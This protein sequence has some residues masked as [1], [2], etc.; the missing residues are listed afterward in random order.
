[1]RYRMLAAL[2]VPCMACSCGAS[3]STIL[4]IDTNA[5]LDTSGDSAAD[6]FGP[7]V[8]AEGIGPETPGFEVPPDAASDTGDAGCQTGS[9]CFGDPCSGADDCTSG[10]CVDHMGDR[11]CTDYCVEECPAGWACLQ[12]PGPDLLFA[13]ASDFPKLCRPC[14]VDEDCKADLGG[15]GRCLSYGAEGSFCGAVCGGGKL[16]PEDFTCKDALTVDGVVVSQCVANAGTCSCSAT[17]VALA[18]ST[19]CAVANQAGSCPGVRVCTEQGLTECDAATPAA[20]ECNGLDDD[21]NGQTDE[22]T[23][24]DGNDCT[25]DGCVPLTGCFHEELGGIPCNDADNCTLGDQCV[26][27][28]CVG[29]LV[30]CEDG[31]PCTDD[32]CDGT[33]GCKFP[34]SSGLCDDD[35]PCTFGD[36]CQDGKCKPG[37]ALS[38][39]DGND[40]T[41]DS[42]DT[43]VGCLHEAADASCDDG[44]P[45]TVGDACLDG[46]CVAGG[47]MDCDDDNPC[48]DDWCGPGG[49][50]HVPNT[51]PCNDGSSCTVDDACSQGQCAGGTA[52]S[53]DDGNPCTSDSCNPLLGCKHTN[54]SDPCD[55]SDPCTLTDSC[56]G[57]VCIGVGAQNCDDDNPCTTDFCEPMAGCS[58][59]PAVASCDDGNPCTVSD[60]CTAG[61]CVGGPQLACDDGNVCTNDACSPASGC[62]HLPNKLP[63]DDSNSCTTDDHCDAGKCISSQALACNDD[64]PCTTDICLPQGGCQ[65]VNNAA[66]C[67][68]GDS[69]TTGDVCKAGKCVA[70]TPVACDDG[71]PC[72][73]DACSGGSCTHAPATATC[74][75][76]NA[77]TLADTCTVGKCKGTSTLDCDDDN[78]CT[79][80][81][82]D[83]VQGCTHK[84]NN[85]PC[86]DNDSCTVGDVC[87][88]GACVSGKK[89]DC[90]DGNP[91]TMDAC[92][93][94]VCTHAPAAG[95]CDDGNPC[96]TSDACSGGTCKGTVA[97]DCNDDN[98]CTTDS[99]S[100]LTGCVYTNN[101]SPCSDANT[102]TLGDTCKD[103]AC[104]PGP[105][106]DCSD[107][108][109]CTDGVCVNGTGCV[110]APAA[111]P[112][113]DNNP[114]T[115][116]E[117]CQA[118]V[119]T[120]TAF[121]DCNDNNPCTKDSCNILSG[122]SY[123]SLS[124][125]CTDN[126]ACTNGDVC[127][128]GKCVPGPQLVCNDGKSCTT[129]TCDPVVGCVFTQTGQCCTTGQ[130][131]VD[132]PFGST[133]GWLST[134]CCNQPN[135]RVANEQ[136]SVLTAAFTDSIPGDSVP[137]TVTVLWGIEHACNSGNSMI[138]RLN[139]TDIG[140]W[141]SQNGPDCSC[142]NMAVGTASFN[143][144]T[145]AYKTGG[146]SNVL[147]IFHNAGGSCH[148]SITNAP[149][150]PV[151]TAVRV[152]ISYGCP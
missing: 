63:C 110:Y 93:G 132:I 80:D 136:G 103:G 85:A 127:T 102:C 32:V 35:D 43:A 109:I 115:T 124:G 39:D 89:V 88:L 31:N 46:K 11:V 104:V 112:C 10:L 151:G 51:A 40:C 95:S 54:S 145:N 28:E 58:H 29:E 84:V 122:C 23:C 27:G 13:C 150:A 152:T 20:E 47:A 101:T 48:T 19:P 52:L 15:E 87:A 126:N 64:N 113:N 119:C 140:T 22:A 38:C 37:I 114:C 138:F 82:C 36:F 149:G 25:K 67:S 100:P 49:C 56:V 70:G 133:T 97:L 66:V 90:N 72:T 21:C 92:S 2:L 121:K 123:E 7:D 71:N 120:A 147:T 139:G 3:P 75:D 59:T 14:A 117:Q 91:C 12:V 16:C 34:P 30:T 50:Q 4:S 135:Y 9:G 26:D 53:C 111:G 45:C 137:K 148:E 144:P 1:M 105:T 78:P 146:A 86:S 24:D 77:C 98:V 44:N 74:D 69:C 6:R 73:A 116:A 142:G 107:G 96:T 68:D 33:T 125:G 42:C 83:P 8:A 99:C 106:L 81:A 57:G 5:T 55:D 128:N 141:G 94:G 129:D 108:N 143:A 131:V 134:G 18:L 62:E 130:I 76:G 79:T 60:K 118:G 17:A 65:F 61:K 41:K